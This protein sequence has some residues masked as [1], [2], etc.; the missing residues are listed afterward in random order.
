MTYVLTIFKVADFAKW[1][2]VFDGMQGTAQSYGGVKKPQVFQNANNANEAIL[3]SEWQDAD[4]AR[5]FF[6]SP[7]LRQAQQ[8]GGLQGPPTIYF[9]NEV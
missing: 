8:Q 9:M 7:E 3:L 2:S 4:R 5:A 6:A 1:R